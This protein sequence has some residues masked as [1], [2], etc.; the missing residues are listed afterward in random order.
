MGGGPELNAM[1]RQVN[2]LGIGEDVTLTGRISDNDVMEALSTADICVSPDPP[3]P[4]NDVS[5][6][7]KTLEYM[8][9]G[10]PVVAFNLKETRV[11]GGDAALYADTKESFVA[12]IERLLDDFA[13]RDHLGRL[14]R[15]RIEKKLSWDHSVPHLLRAYRHALIREAHSSHKRHAHGTPHHAGHDR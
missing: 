5:T 3:T 4:L 6:M 7:N 11:S 10:K 2:T 13:L 1:R 14:G 12:A 9:I 8:A 15:E